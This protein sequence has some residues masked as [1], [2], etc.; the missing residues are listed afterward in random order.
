MKLL[1]NSSNYVLVELNDN[2]EIL[3]SYKTPVAGRNKLGYFR[4]DKKWSVTTSK[5]IDTYLKYVSVVGQMP[6]EEINTMLNK[7]GEVN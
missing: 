3:F 5:H 4:T 7:V 2:L 6:Q 1:E